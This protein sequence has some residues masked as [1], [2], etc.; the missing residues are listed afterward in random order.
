MQL[1]EHVHLIGSG[2]FG[3]TQS[4]DHD[5]NIYLLDGGAELALVDTGAGCDQG[6]L[7][8][9]VRAA[10]FDPA[11]VRSVFLTHKHADHSG[12]AGSFGAEH[13]AEVL[14]S[15]ETAAAVLDEPAFNV[16]LTAARRSGAYP[17]SYRFRGPA[18]VTTVADGDKV[19]IGQLT[20]TVVD[21][22]GHCAGHLS[23]LLSAPDGSTAAFTGD[24]LLPGGEIVLQPIAD[25][26]IPASLT[27]IER[28]AA[29]RFDALMPGH[30][31][32]VLR[33]GYR[34]AEVALRAVAGGGMPA[35]FRTPALPSIGVPG[36]C[37]APLEGSD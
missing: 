14:A 23:Y 28:L 9:L 3:M 15:A 31:C 17:A 6:R 35:A 16:N 13:G 37:A 1:T 2:R 22:V 27:A 10:G 18:E 36:A 4:D 20:M 21:T 11:R 12:G 29:L 32:P 19:P 24:A 8:E 5:C 26:S 7:A 30:Q 25:L 34:H 33:A